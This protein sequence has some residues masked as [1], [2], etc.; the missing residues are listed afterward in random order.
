MAYSQKCLEELRNQV[1][2]VDLLS[3]Y[4]DLKKSGSSYKACCPFHEE[5]TPSFVVKK[6]DRHYHCFGCG[7]HGDA[8][9]FLVQA[10]GMKFQ[11]AIELLGQRY[12]VQLENEEDPRERSQKLR[13]HQ[14]MKHALDFFK[15][16]LRQEERGYLAREYLKQRDFS[17]SCLEKFE[18]GYAPD[19]PYSLKKYLN[20]LKFSDEELLEFG[21]IRQHADTKVRRDFF[22]HRLIFP[23][24][25]AMGRVI[26]FSARQIDNKSF[27]GKYINSPETPLF[28]KSRAL[29][30]IAY[31]RARIVKEQQVILVE[32]QFDA[33]ALIEHGLDLGVAPLG[34]A[35]GHEH[36]QELVRLGV[37]KAWI[38]F[39]SDEAGTK[40]AKKAGFLLHSK[41]ID[42]SIVTLPRA[43]D[44]DS[45]IRQFGIEGFIDALHDGKRFLDFWASLEGSSVDMSSPA[46]KVDVLRKMAH[47]IEQIPDSLLVHESFLRLTQIMNLS[48]DYLSE[49]SSKKERK[50]TLAKPTKTALRDELKKDGVEADFLRWLLYSGGYREEFW[51]VALQYKCNT[52][53]YDQEFKNAFSWLKGRYEKGES[54]LM[55]D[56]IAQL[57]NERWKLVF[58]SLFSKRLDYENAKVLFTKT[59]NDLRRRHW[60]M[61]LQDVRQKLSSGQLEEE[62]ALSIA[63]EYSQ[64]F[65]QEPVELDECELF[66]QA[67]A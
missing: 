32:G 28:K 20:S 34:T 47:E 43:E 12:G 67:Y 14:L 61:K 40:A 45:F 6:A 46:A 64:I 59:L 65:E 56:I 53:L 15:Q 21:L 49:L 58:I 27:G 38:A 54:L 19:H 25:D 39:D 17:T 33:L 48:S 1:D 52:L 36:V 5:R 3:S 26:A 23:V 35:F 22:Q 42:T 51:K 63:R 29:Y 55:S 37:K 8:V 2:L 9:S 44:P 13:G 18:L 50:P 30:G 11:D 7:A 10:Q 62:E 41:G 31:S 66:S 60:R 57:S 24:H 16:E 4:I